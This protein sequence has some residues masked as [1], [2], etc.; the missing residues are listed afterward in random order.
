VRPSAQR[1]TL[2]EWL[3]YIE[4]VHPRSIEMGLARVNAVREALRLSPGFPLITVGGTNGKGSVC[5]MLEAILQSAG[6]EVGCYTSPH[7][8][9]YN[10]RV[11]VGRQE[12]SDAALGEALAAVDCARGATPL[13]YFEFST[14]AAM[15]LFVRE[16][17]DCAILEVGLG[18]R[19]DA[20]NVF[21]ADCAV[22]TSIALDHMDY[23]GPTRE[24][25]AIEKAGIVRAGRPAICGDE[26][27]PVTLLQEADRIG[28]KMLR[29]G[30]EF[31]YA[32]QRDQWRYWGP[33]CE[34][35]ALPHP[36]L[37]GQCQLANAASAIAALD[38]LHAK[39]PFTVADVRR[40]LLD[41]ENPG[42]FQIL[43]GRPLVILDVGASPR[44]WGRCRRQAVPSRCSRCCGTR[45]SRASSERQPD[46]SMA[47]S[48]PAFPD[49]EEAMP[50]SCASTSPVPASRVP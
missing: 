34:R 20:V 39:L 14:L 44:I 13:T 15:W 45:T 12:A 33:R 4:R 40:G 38:T 25:I 42:R 43:P 26:D 10:E 29:L 27:P 30:H 2:E 48:S 19:L 23:L 8:L 1:A 41:T 7:L 46:R 18:G 47:G 32:A 3:H 24:R 9:R 49:R 28:A 16:A 11:R 21:D 5:A 17:V 22:V 36:A 6:Y 50:R 35:Y 31:G 37:R